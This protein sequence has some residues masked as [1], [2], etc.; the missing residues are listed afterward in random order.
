MNIQKRQRAYRTG[1]PRYLPH[2]PTVTKLLQH[3][4]S[5]FFSGKS[6]G[7]GSRHRYLHAC[8][9]TPQSQVP[10]PAEATDR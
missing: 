1:F 8:H 3:L 7:V 5:R 2:L 9:R 10:L 4:S 6:S